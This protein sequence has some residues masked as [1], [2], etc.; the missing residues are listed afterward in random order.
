MSEGSFARQTL[1]ANL[2]K[3]MRQ[4]Y[5]DYAM[6]VI[7]GRALPDIRD[8]LKPVHRRVLYAMFELGNDWNKP[9]KKSARIVGDVIGKY[10]PHGDTA[11]YDTIVR[12]AQNF[13]MRYMLIDGQGNFGSVDGDPPAAMRY[14]EIRLARVAHELLADLDKDTVDFGP[15][16]DETETQPLVLPSRVPNFLVNGSAGIAVGMA[17]NVPPHNLA[18][19]IDACLA[20]IDN[21][22]VTVAE[23]MKHVPGPDFPTAG[24]INGKSGI[25]QA[26]ETGRGR[27]V[28][29]ARTHFESVRGD[30]NA[31]IVSELP[32]QVNKARLMEEIA[33]L[34]RNKRVEGISA[35]R[36]ESDKSGMR[37]VIELKRGEQEDVVLNNLFR[38]T[39]M[40]TVFGINMVALTGNQPRIF[41]LKEAL[42]EYVAHRR[43]VVTR[44]AI[45]DLAKARERIHIL[46]G[47]AVAL[48]NIDTVIALIKA[49][50]SSAEAK[51][52]LLAQLWTSGVVAEML[53]RSDPSLSRPDWLD[54]GF[55]LTEHGYRLSAA[56]SQAILDMRLHRLTGLEQEKI[57][58]EYS[59]VI[60]DILALLEVLQNPDRLVEVI[61]GELQAVRDQYADD[62][63]TEII[64]G[65]LDFSMEDLIPEEDVV[66][67]M[68]HA[69]YVKSQPIA[70]YSAQRRGGRGK[71]ATRT[72]EEDF[73]NQMFVVNSH[74]TILCFSD[75]GKVYWLRAFQFPQA[76]RHARG[77]PLVNLL[78]LGSDESVTAILPVKEYDE[79]HFIFMATSRG[80]VKK[81][82]LTDFSRPRSIGLRAVVLQEGD[83]L[84][85]VT[86]TDGRQDILLATDAGKVCRFSE[87]DVRVL[88]RATR[89]VRGIGLK[90]GQQVISLMS[91]SPG[92]GEP[93]PD[94][95]EEPAMLVSTVNG[96]GKRTPVADFPRKRRGAQG[97]IAIKTA[98]RNGKLINAGIVGIQDEVILITT[99]G[100]LIRTRVSEI[101]VLQ[102]NTQ[103]V[104]LISLDDGASLVGVC[105]IVDPDKDDMEES[106]PQGPLH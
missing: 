30:R 31:I 77:R 73:V 40:Q 27:V 3:E 66:I 70:E 75:S 13:S 11:V 43:E 50:P 4:S 85:G 104:R 71:I 65:E 49:S 54:E 63:R 18:E 86:I 38:H 35:I 21:P 2:E 81:C 102:R 76:G 103:G 10:H 51:E 15:N 33:D 88:G 53:S 8:G 94:T 89:G 69:G 72:K 105:K 12:M 32:Y 59:D 47:L 24:I 22:E 26:Y 100:I 93:M 5:L 82:R 83:Y 41:S 36:D 90:A 19:I 14:T 48:A 61:R 34:V 101:S 87:Q 98:G 64:E 23:L 29:R 91:C 42:A 60:G 67:T 20:L 1:P 39:S 57:V 68:S 99:D 46:E 28:I 55:G 96:Y 80:V 95:S 62:R 79:N 37:M 58:K 52:R 7:V 97:V 74:D 56:Q 44:R 45:F 25:I 84:I 9:Y 17:T 92:N 16:Y 6:S 78:P 106:G